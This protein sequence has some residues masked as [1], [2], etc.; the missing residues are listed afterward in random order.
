MPKCLSFFGFG[1]HWGF[2]DFLFSW[3][4]VNSIPHNEKKIADLESDMVFEFFLFGFWFFFDLS[5]NYANPLI[6]KSHETSV[7]SI[8][9]LC[10]WSIGVLVTEM[11]NVS[12]LTVLG[13][14][15]NFFMVLWFWMF[16]FPTVLLF[17]IETNFPLISL[18][19]PF[20]GLFKVLFFIPYLSTTFSL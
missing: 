2:A 20:L 1:V 13:F 3:H 15:S 8:C 4:L 19:T 5:G 10:L 6:S 18:Q 12:V 14:W 17:L 16:F 7:C 11:W 9:Y